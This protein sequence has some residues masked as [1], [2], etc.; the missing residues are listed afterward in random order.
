MDALTQHLA[1]A[2]QSLSGTL[3]QLLARVE[4][5]LPDNTQI[6]WN[7]YVAALSNT[8]VNDLVSDIS[9]LKLTPATVTLGITTTTAVILAGTLLTAGTKLQEKVKAPAKKKKL[10]KA[11]KANKEIQK[12]LDFVEETY[13]PQIDEYI[14]NFLSLLDNDRQYKYKYFEEMLLKEL[15]K[16]DGVDVAGNDVLRDNRKKVIKFIQ[17]HQKRLDKFKKENL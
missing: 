12:I 2:K 1:A 11:Q 14:E 7:N 3:K 10:T 8:S 17:E 9:S 4:S 13:V 16:L 15:M 5:H 6:A